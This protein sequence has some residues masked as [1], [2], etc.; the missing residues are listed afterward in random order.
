[1]FHFLTH[2]KGISKTIQWVPRALSQGVKRPGLEADTHL[3]LV[4]RSRMVE[5]YLQFPYV[6]LE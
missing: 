5:L 3:R 6:F 1:M 4:S 2:T